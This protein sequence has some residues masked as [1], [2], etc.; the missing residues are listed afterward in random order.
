MSAVSEA[1][2]GIRWTGGALSTGW[3]TGK[4]SWRQRL[5]GS[6][7]L[8][9]PRLPLCRLAEADTVTDSNKNRAAGAPLITTGCRGFAHTPNPDTDE[10]NR[11]GVLSA[12]AGK[13]LSHPRGMTSC[14]SPFQLAFLGVCDIYFLTSGWHLIKAK[15]SQPVPF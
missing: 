4:G 2:G 13:S 6:P 5:T 14:P 3:K 8:W 12:C 11:D 15:L 9:S 7:A 10:D 1:V